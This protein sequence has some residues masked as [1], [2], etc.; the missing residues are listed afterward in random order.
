MLITHF[1]QVKVEME[2]LR[3]NLVHSFYTIV[4]AALYFLVTSKEQVSRWQ[5]TAQS[6]ELAAE[7]EKYHFYFENKTKLVTFSCLF[8]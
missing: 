5:L 3:S 1:Q 4:Y 6:F 8:A 2:T 7:I